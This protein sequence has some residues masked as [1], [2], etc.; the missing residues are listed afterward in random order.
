MPA[1]T[2]RNVVRR[3]G[4]IYV[5][6]SDKVEQEFDSVAQLRQEVRAALDDGGLRDMM[7]T[8]LLASSIRA[9]NDGSLLRDLERRTIDMDI[10][11]LTI[12]VRNG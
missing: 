3:N 6:W 2:V 9:A 10:N 8:L 5:R 12:E 4:K 7:R 1:L 11:P